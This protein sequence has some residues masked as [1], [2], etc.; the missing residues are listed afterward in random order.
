[1][2]FTVNT[3]LIKSY[4]YFLQGDVCRLC[5]K[6]NSYTEIVNNT[7]NLNGVKIE[8][9]DII[10]DCLNLEL[11]DNY[12]NR[13]CDQCFELLKKF[14]TF[15]TFCKDADCKLRDILNKGLTDVKNEVK[16]EFDTD[17]DDK[18]TNSK[19]KKFKAKLKGKKS[20]SE[21]YCFICCSQFDDTTNFKNH[22]SECHGIENGLYKCF[23]C[24]KRFK[25][26]RTRTSHETNFCKALKEGYKCPICSRFL[27]VRK[28][29]EAHMRYHAGKE[30]DVVESSENIFKCRK[31][32]ASYKT[33]DDLKDHMSTHDSIDNHF[34]CETCGNVFLRQDYLQ[35]HIMIHMG[36]KRHECSYCNLR[37]VQK[38]SLNV[39]LR[40]HTG[41]RPYKCD[42][43][44]Q[45]CVSSSNLRAHRRRHLGIKQFECA[46][47]SKKFGYKISLAE[48]IASAHAPAQKHQCTLCGAI[49]SRKKGLQ[50]HSARKHADIL[51][52]NLKQTDPVQTQI[53]GANV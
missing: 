36:V 2:E 31:C 16:N 34:V 5:W 50:R 25:N 48:H 45:R 9:V 44:P 52:Q 17:F 28:L 21:N 19:T 51:K 13:I 22:N 42:V 14:Y 49:Y 24:E 53:L 46:I 6:K 4:E 10:K 40:K 20:K 39:H 47:C 43:C 35:K 33:K 3:L 32:D 29:Y 38:S 15:K 7:I 1:M 18:D 26:T 27:P 37:F 30:S 23:G 8:V 12:P 41:E 11:C